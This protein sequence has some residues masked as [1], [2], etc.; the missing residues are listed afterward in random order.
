MSSST[1]DTLAPH[2]D[3]SAL[4]DFSAGGLGVAARDL[5][6]T[7]LDGCSRCRQMLSS[8][9]RSPHPP[10]EV[11]IDDQ[12][13]H[14]GVDTLVG[15]LLGEYRVLERINQGG[16]GVLYRGE[17][18]VIGKAV[19]IKV[20]LPE[21]AADPNLVHRLLGEARAVNSIRHPN[22]VDIFALGQLA[23]GRHYVVMEL[24]QGES[25]ADLLVARGRLAQREAVVVLDQAMAALEAAHAAGVIHRDLKPENI[26]V[27]Q[28]T[29]GWRVTLLDF[30]LAKQQ[31]ST[32]TAPNVVLGTP[33]YMAP[34]QIMGKVPTPAIDIYA[35]GIL[36]W[37]LLVG[38]EP[39][40]GGSLVQVM[41][42]HLDA[43]VPK[44]GPV[45]GVSVVLAA[46][47]ERMMA[48]EPADRPDAAQ[49]RGTLARLRPGAVQAQ[50]V[51]QLI[52]PASVVTLPE[53]VTAVAA[54]PVQAAE[55]KRPDPALLET[56]PDR[57]RPT[58]P[59]RPSLKAPAPA[60]L[61][62]QPDRFAGVDGPSLKKR[63][64][65][66]V[67]AIAVGLGSGAAG[68]YVAGAA[69]DF[70]RANPEAAGLG[71]TLAASRV[72]A[73]ALHDLAARQAALLQLTLL[74]DR[75]KAGE[76]PKAIAAELQALRAEY[77][78]D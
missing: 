76:A 62:T 14:V 17:Q 63:V 22:I 64:L 39:Y 71:Q 70:E 13:T 35:M 6:I 7:H 52:A 32:L 58:V 20:L 1:P 48:K 60:L 9:T 46:L 27:D 72:K 16:M 50:E 53:G 47:V 2:P 30:G 66:V 34:E 42:Q 38:H 24:L 77:G 55:L 36:A 61:A 19:A 40:A 51:T 41:R 33:G 5:L 25:L 8:L 75:R 45:P 29:D 78:L 54:R 49:V 4:L 18:P 73:E 3:E 65:L 12:R 67:A 56:L 43:P 37:R 74:E 69:P 28:R 57:T 21:V 26:F 31:G 11:P 23:D 10:G 15:Q 44:L 59:E 68:L